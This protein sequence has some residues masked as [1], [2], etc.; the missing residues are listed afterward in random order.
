MRGTIRL[1][2]KPGTTF[3]VNKPRRLQ[4]YA[5]Q[6]IQAEVNK[7]QNMNTKKGGSNALYATFA[8]GVI[9]IVSTWLI[10]ELKIMYNGTKK[11]MK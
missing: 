6:S 2:T 8:F 4:N 9:P 5:H 10:A 11:H 7:V 1:C 3:T